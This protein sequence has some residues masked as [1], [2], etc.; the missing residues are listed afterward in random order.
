MKKIIILLT[1]CLCMVSGM[2]MSQGMRFEKGSFEQALAKTKAEGKLLFV[3]AYAVWCGPCKWMS[4]NI[5]VD[6]EVGEYFN[7]YFVGVKIDVERGEGPSVKARYAIEG[8][9]GYLFMDSA[10][11]I[12]FRASGSMPKEKFMELLEDAR[13]AAKDPDNVG[14]MAARYPMEL[15][16]EHFLKEYLDKLKASGSAG[17]YDVVEQYLKIQK[18]MAPSSGEMVRF[19]YDHVNSLVFGGEADRILQENLWTYA[20]DAYV[21]KGI[22]EKF[23]QLGQLLA[24]NTTEYAIQKKDTSL[25][26]LAI[27]QV[28]AYG[29]KPQDGQKERLLVYYYSQTG[30]GENY[31]RLVRP[32]IESFYKTLDAKALRE[33]H[34]ELVKKRGD[35]S[36]GGWR[37]YA[38]INSEKL[39]YMASEYA[40]FVSSREDGELLLEWATCV[41]EML[42]SDSNNAAFYAKALYLYGDKEKG[43]RLMTDV[44]S[45]NPERKKAEGFALDLEAMKNGKAISL[46]F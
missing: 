10:G 38:M 35:V 5:F 7:Q 29:L 20:W 3:D 39:R 32:Q 15:D 6:S 26:D 23:Q 33:K 14:R 17:Y 19:L 16:N 1:V 34:E 25:L 42:P 2:A 44:V 12:V 43:L 31:K 21:R 41:Y 8:L 18:S 45:H 28:E 13:E 27:K 37:S 22:R 46:T 40:R 4:D 30:D 11:N 9:P 36:K 24:S